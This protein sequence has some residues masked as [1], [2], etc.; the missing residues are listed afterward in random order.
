ME[1]AIRKSL[2]GSISLFDDQQWGAGDKQ[3]EQRGLGGG[4]AL[5]GRLV[6]VYT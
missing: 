6:L 1:G 4:T 5:M 3:S 2:D